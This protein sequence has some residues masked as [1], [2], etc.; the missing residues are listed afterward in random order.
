MM[1]RDAGSEKTCSGGVA[2]L[3]KTVLQGLLHDRLHYGG[4]LCDFRLGISRCA[5]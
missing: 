5:C 4:V 3:Q 1:T 2:C